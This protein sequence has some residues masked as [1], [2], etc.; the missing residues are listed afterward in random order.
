MQ[1]LHFFFILLLLFSGI[2]VF[3]S[4]NPIHSVLF[5]ILT[6]CDAALILFLLH[7]DFIGFLF[8]IIY[9]GAI[10]V[11]FLFVIMMLHVK[12]YNTQNFLYFP[13]FFLIALIFIF[14]FFLILNDT[15]NN[16]LLDVSF[17]FL[18]FVDCLTNIDIF[19]QVLYNYFLACFLLAGFVLLVAMIGAIVLTLNFS[20]QRQNKFVL[21]QFSRCDNIIGSSKF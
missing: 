19:G 21:R 11:L 18:N 7:V 17:Y 16:F 5:L 8:I 4:N 3:I 20:D 1:I 6:F 2:L 12:I 9:V 13:A 14:Q 10:A 15:F